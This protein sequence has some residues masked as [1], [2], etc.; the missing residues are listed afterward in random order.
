MPTKVYAKQK[1]V[2]SEPQ[3]VFENALAGPQQLVNALSAYLAH[4]VAQDNGP[5]ARNLK[6]LEALC[7][8]IETGKMDELLGPLTDAINNRVCAIEEGW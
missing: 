1:P 3:R 2:I 6:R 5:Q 8:A 7:E 4:R